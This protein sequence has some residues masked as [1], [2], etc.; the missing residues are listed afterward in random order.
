[1]DHNGDIYL[2]ECYLSLE[3]L[4]KIIST[5]DRQHAALT[6]AG[7]QPDQ[8]SRLLGRCEKAVIG[9]IYREIHRRKQR[10]LTAGIPP[11]FLKVWFR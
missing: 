6:S 4:G 8:R 7:S 2:F 1:M 10:R 5:F 9:I 3:N 11:K